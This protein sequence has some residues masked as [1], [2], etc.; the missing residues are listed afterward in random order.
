MSIRKRSKEESSS[1]NQAVAQ[2]RTALMRQASKAEEQQRANAL[3]RC[4]DLARQFCNDMH[5]C[6]LAADDLTMMFC[7]LVLGFGNID[8]CSWG[9]RKNSTIKGTIAVVY[10]GDDASQ[11]LLSNLLELLD[12]RKVLKFN[13]NTRDFLIHAGGVDGAAMANSTMFWHELTPQWRNSQLEFILQTTANGFVTT[14]T[15]EFSGTV[16]E[17]KMRT[18]KGPINHLLTTAATPQEFGEEFLRK[19]LWWNVS[20]DRRE[21]L[22]GSVRRVGIP[23]WKASALVR[24]SWQ[25]LSSQSGFRRLSPDDSEAF[26]EVEMEYL[27]EVEIKDLPAED[28]LHTLIASH[29]LWNQAHRR[30]Y[31]KG[32]RLVLVSQIEDYNA[33][34]PVFLVAMKSANTVSNTSHAE[35]LQLYPL[36]MKKGI[37]IEELAVELKKSTRT[38]KRYMADWK[39]L[40]LVVNGKR[41]SGS[42]IIEPGPAFTKV[43]QQFNPYRQKQ[44]F[45][46][47]LSNVM[48]GEISLL[49]LPQN[50]LEVCQCEL[51]LA[52]SSEHLACHENC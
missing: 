31:T 35:F 42:A 18:T 51:H 41:I 1:E 46:A 3:L 21:D 44:A 39:Q 12:P 11:L 29:A 36:L 30:Q 27:R 48:K 2:A 38:A 49:P 14:A 24:R 20:N 6:G 16:R 9:K 26:V 50:A 40:N 33:V 17:V 19:S 10:G 43:L 37:T 22:C 25:L 34:L 13:T 8:M 52:F 32:G 45:E 23:D 4:G 28:L 47:A 15:T 5:Y 7:F